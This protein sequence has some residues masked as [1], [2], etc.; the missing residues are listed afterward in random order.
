MERPLLAHP[1]GAALVA[2]ND[3]KGE[4]R[5]VVGGVPIRHGELQNAGSSWSV[6]LGVGGR[7][8]ILFKVVEL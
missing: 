5:T 2:L 7:A 4:R 1:E 6:L 8:G 3:G